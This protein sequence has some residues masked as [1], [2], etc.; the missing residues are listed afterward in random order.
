MTDFTSSLTVR[1]FSNDT[2]MLES[3][4]FMFLK[5]KMNYHSRVPL[6]MQRNKP[7]S[8]LCIS[9]TSGL[10]ILLPRLGSLA[11][12][13]F[14]TCSP[15]SAL[16]H[17][18]CFHS[19]PSNQLSHICR[20]HSPAC[21]IWFKEILIRCLF[22]ENQ[23]LVVRCGCT[24]RA[25]YRVFG[26]RTQIFLQCLRLAESISQNPAKEFTQKFAHD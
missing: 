7:K 16:A 21:S 22:A 15:A 9:L 19:P 8:W 12:G 26:S 25:M 17:A 11:T 24:W 5:C 20:Y 10:R 3:F 18:P 23:N 1:W 6:L 2:S 13:E 4:L 14:R